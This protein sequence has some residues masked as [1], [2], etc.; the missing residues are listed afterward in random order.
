MHEHFLFN[1]T[2]SYICETSKCPANLVQIVN[3]EL[4]K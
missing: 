2:A 1:I 4:K 3:D